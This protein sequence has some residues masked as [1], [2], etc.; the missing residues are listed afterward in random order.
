[1]KITN[2]K[3]LPQ[4]IVDAVANDPYDAGDTDYSATTLISPAYQVML[5]AKHKEALEEDVADRLWAMYGSAI[6]TI[7]ERAAGPDDIV[8]KRYFSTMADKKISAQIDHYRDGHITDWKLTAAYKIKRALAGDIREW[9]EQLNIQAF[10]M[11]RNGLQITSLHVGAMCRDWSKQKY[12]KEDGYPDQIEF[13]DIKLWDGN[14]Q[15]DFI[16]ERID[17]MQQAKPCTQAERW[18]DDPTYALIKEGAARAVKVEK[19][20]TALAIYCAG[21]QLYD[22]EGMLL[23]GYSMETREAP[24]RRCEFYCNVNKFCDYYKSKYMVA[25]DLPFKEAK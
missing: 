8:E 10:L 3:N 6:H 25:E 17:A 21:K 18:Q 12:G 22:N 14:Q 16:H 24:N 5:R 7:I 20:V 23:D 11:V 2:R 13:I 9:E 1:M 15:L 4:I 19:S